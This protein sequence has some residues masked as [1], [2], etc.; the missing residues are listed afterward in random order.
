LL[1]ENGP[2]TKK[3][4]INHLKQGRLIYILMNG[5]PSRDSL[6]FRD[7]ST[8][9]TYA[10]KLIKD[11]KGTDEKVQSAFYIDLTLTLKDGKIKKH[12]L[13]LKDFYR[14]GVQDYRIRQV[15]VS[16]DEQHV[17]FI[18]EKLHYGKQG[19]SIRYMVETAKLF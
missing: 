6:E 7:F 19:P 3:F 17:V 18:I 15:L 10:V 2:L 13:G 8:S 5:E 1:E 4:G 14:P 12:V 9:A 11:I 16:P